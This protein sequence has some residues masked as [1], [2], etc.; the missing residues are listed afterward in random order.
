M[1][2]H[3]SLAILG[4]RA[5]PAY[6][7]RPTRTRSVFVVGASSNIACL[8]S[9]A[10]RSSL[11]H[12]SHRVTRDHS[13]AHDRDHSTAHDRTLRC[14][15]QAITRPESAGEPREGLA[16]DAKGNE[17]NSSLRA[18]ASR[19]GRAT[20]QARSSSTGNCVGLPRGCG[21]WP[22]VGDVGDP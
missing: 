20:A 12:Q 3:L 6:T 4:G 8:F 5:P 11:R 1:I 19:P 15:G 9:R 10:L 22:D 2:F 21:R 7:A 13:T 17:R 14:L 16:T 18:A